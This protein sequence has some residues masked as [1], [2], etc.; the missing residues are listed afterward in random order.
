MCVETEGEEKTLHC[1][2]FRTPPNKYHVTGDP[3]SMITGCHQDVVG[4]ASATGLVELVRVS[5]VTRMSFLIHL[6]SR[7]ALDGYAW[8]DFVES[9]ARVAACF[10]AKA[11]KNHV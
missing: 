2:L 7:E 9:R 3:V 8:N 4:C 5:L 6:T 11:N 1:C 10:V